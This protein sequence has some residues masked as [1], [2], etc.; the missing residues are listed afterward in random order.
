MATSS[1]S[2]LDTAISPAP[3]TS[4]ADQLARAQLSLELLD[5]I[6]ACKS[7]EHLLSVLKE[8]QSSGGDID[9]A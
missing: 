6:E 2:S 8:N 4:L 9:L 1:S 7:D 3:V 5:R